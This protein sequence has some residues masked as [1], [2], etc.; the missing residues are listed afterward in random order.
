MDGID[1]TISRTQATVQWENI[2]FLCIQFLVQ[3]L[4]YIGPGKAKNPGESLADNT[5]KT[6]LDRPIV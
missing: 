1:R 5:E 3:F 2:C 6:E 4:T